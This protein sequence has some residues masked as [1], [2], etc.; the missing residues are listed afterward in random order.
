M[1]QDLMNSCIDPDQF[2]ENVIMVSKELSENYDK[3]N[4]S[5][6]NGSFGKTAQFCLIYLDLMEHQHIIHIAVQENNFT[7]RITVREYFLSL[8]FAT[9]KIKLCQIWSMLSSEH[10]VY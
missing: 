8:Y 7:E 9:N 2:A 3:F 10:E 6:R 1:P 5:I 4:E